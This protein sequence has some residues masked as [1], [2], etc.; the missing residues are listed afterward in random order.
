MYYIEKND[1]HIKII[2][3]FNIV[4]MVNNKIL[5]PE[6]KKETDV[7]KIARKTKKAL[8]QTFSRKIVVSKEIQKST[9][10]MNY[11]YSYNLNIVNGKWLYKILC[12][13]I[14]DYIINK[15]KF[16]KSEA[17]IS[18]L[19][20]DTTVIDVES[21][22]IIL[23]NYKNVNIISNHREKF[24]NLEKSFLE[25]EGITLIISNNKRQALNKS[26]VILN[27]D[28]PE[29]E[30]NK[31]SICEKAIIV[32]FEEKAKV[33]KKRFE[34]TIINDY[35][36]NVDDDILYQN[37]GFTKE[38]FEKYFRKEVYEAYFNKKQSF[39]SIRRILKE[40]KVTISK[41]F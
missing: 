14:L 22:K 5:L 38:E 20:N 16:K 1:K 10:Y 27:L 21:I 23:R 36:I 7:E 31:Y 2:N 25:N 29:E 41:L 33:Y 26:N 8:N 17:K 32:N 18:I 6:I 24:K 35:E 28:Y 9:K 39:S 19:V 34:G 13:E 4:K 37:V 15:N 11:L 3:F 30:L 12:F 40:D